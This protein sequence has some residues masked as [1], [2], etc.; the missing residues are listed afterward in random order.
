MISVVRRRHGGYARV[1]TWHPQSIIPANVGI[2]PLRP[3]SM[4]RDHRLFAAVFQNCSQRMPIGFL[5]SL[6]R[7]EVAG[8]TPSL[9]KPSALIKVS[10][11]AESPST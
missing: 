8:M 7:I 4:H 2:Q 9:N 10:T 11:A 5:R 3:D 6:R 1:K